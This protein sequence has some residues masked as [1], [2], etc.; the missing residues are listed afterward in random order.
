MTNEKLIING[1]NTENGMI[2]VEVKVNEL[3]SRNELYDT[4]AILN[5]L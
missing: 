4:E 5:Q 1:K 3:I 2:E